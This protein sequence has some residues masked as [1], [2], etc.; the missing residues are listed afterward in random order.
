M[1]HRFEE[2]ITTDE[3][4]AR[5]KAHP[6]SDQAKKQATDRLERLRNRLPFQANQITLATTKTPT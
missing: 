1:E 5:I 6:L 2:L 4:F 3:G